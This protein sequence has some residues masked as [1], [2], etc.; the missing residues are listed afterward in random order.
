MAAIK[1]LAYLIGAF[2]F[3]WL[4]VAGFMDLDEDVAVRSFVVMMV[5]IAAWA[6][7]YE[8]RKRDEESRI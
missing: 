7:G 6:F 2:L 5:L 1:I 8:A 3:S 4:V